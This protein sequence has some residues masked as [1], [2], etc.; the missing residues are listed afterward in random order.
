[1]PKGMPQGKPHPEQDRTGTVGGP[2]TGPAIG[3]GA[4]PGR[5]RQINDRREQ[6]PAY[7][8]DERALQHPIMNP[9]GQS[10]S[11][12]GAADALRR[13]A[14]GLSLAL[15]LGAAAVYAR[16]W[17]GTEADRP[18]PSGAPPPAFAAFE[19][20]T[21][22]AWAALRPGP[23]RQPRTG[24]G[25]AA[26]FRLAGTFLVLALGAE[27]D[28]SPA[29]ELRRAIV[30]DLEQGAQI[31]VGEGERIGPML[32]TRVWADRIVVTADGETHEL[33]L[34]YRGGEGAEPPATENGGA[35]D[36]GE[37]ALETTRFGT[38]IAEGRWRLSR[39]A[40]MEYYQ[41]LLDEP[42]RIARLYETFEPIYSADRRIEGY[43]IEVKGEEE[44]LR[45]TGI[46]PGDVVRAVN[47][48]PMTSQRRA[49][50]FIR[51]FAQNRLDTIVV[52]IERDGV[53][54]K[55]IYFTD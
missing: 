50:Y 15:A 19:A 18:A 44:F 6:N 7:G 40:L 49:E 12:G 10:A 41:E 36:T 27:R 17:H 39:P 34:T 21:A 37:P 46:R 1:M 51:E 11:V 52:D 2:S 16:L 45:A 33:R 9:E 24:T 31:L 30:D 4:V 38:R 54:Q 23:N 42:E 14:T 5:S 22:A 13:A 35:A 28:D 26:R 20:P 48:M 47:S 43:R 8:P 32:V 53:R 55:L 29:V 3:G 25:P